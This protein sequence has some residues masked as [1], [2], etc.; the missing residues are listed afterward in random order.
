MN[1]INNVLN[2]YTD[3]E[4]LK[5]VLLIILLCIPMSLYF[6]FKIASKKLFLFSMLSQIVLL[7]LYL[8]I[9]LINELYFASITTGLNQIGL[10]SVL[11]I[12]SLMLSKYGF[13]MISGLGKKNFDP[14]VINRAH[15]KNSINTI[16]I[17]MILGVSIG[18]FIPSPVGQII[19]SISFTVIVITALN[20]IIVR[21]IF[22]DTDGSKK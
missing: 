10:I 2:I 22:P 12:N 3:H 13:D 21:K 15:F 16:I 6:Y 19:L 4:L 11:L 18:L 5:F 1:Y 7:C 17:M 8:V 20:H 14:D 9:A